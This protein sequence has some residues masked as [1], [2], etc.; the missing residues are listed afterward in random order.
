MGTHVE[1]RP[2][3]K[4]KLGAFVWKIVVLIFK[5]LHFLQIGVLFIPFEE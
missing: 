5:A 2:F 1:I 3:L 4:S